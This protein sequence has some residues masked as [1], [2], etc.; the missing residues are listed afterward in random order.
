MYQSIKEYFDYASNIAV[1]DTLAIKKLLDSKIPY[2]MVNGIFF[3]I[4]DKYKELQLSCL[5]AIYKKDGY[6]HSAISEDEIKQLLR[7]M[8]A[9]QYIDEQDQTNGFIK[10]LESF[11]TTEVIYIVPNYALILTDGITSFQIGLVKCVMTESIKSDYEKNVRNINILINENKVGHQVINSQPAFA[12]PAQ[13]F[14]INLKCSPKRA[15]NMAQWYV[16]IAISLF[17]LYA[18]KCKT[19]YG[20]FPRIGELDPLAFEARNGNDSALTIFPTEKKS[21]YGTYSSY[22]VYEINQ[23][24]IKQFFASNFKEVCSK[25][26]LAKSDFV[27]E[28]LQ[29]TLGWMT[30]ARSSHDLSMRFLF[31]FT[32]LEALLTPQGTNT[33]ITDTIAR[34]VATIIADIDTRFTIYNKVK[35][36]Y[37]V[38]SRLVH[39]GSREVAES[40]C[41]QLQY[42]TE[43]VCL[44]IINSS[45]DKDIK[46]FHTELKEAGF[47]RKWGS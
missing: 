29:R 19:D 43:L 14:C 7:T 25:I 46:T 8:A 24:T 1:S 41:D 18:F 12:L 31:F 33:Q 37:D 30:K 39:S 5:K 47:G 44:E 45:I 17:R 13:C 23:E 26:F 10:E 36:L 20:H 2:N 15:N 28:R 16:D 6:N 40:D 11:M 21:S 27:C 3:P 38:R 22:L 34:N 35:G 4:D 42:Y 9:K 32:A